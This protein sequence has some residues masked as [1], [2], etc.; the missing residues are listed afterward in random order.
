M[1]VYS[2]DEEKPKYYW[3]DDRNKPF[4][5]YSLGGRLVLFVP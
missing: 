4:N 1:F 3:S 2:L 5:I